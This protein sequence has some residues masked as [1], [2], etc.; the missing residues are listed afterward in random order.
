MNHYYLKSNVQIEPLFNQWHAHPYLIQP[1]TAAMYLVNAHLSTINSY[2]QMPMA[3]AAALKNPDLIGGPFIDFDGKRVDEVKALKA[4]SEQEFECHITLAN[5]IKKLYELLNEKAKGKPLTELYE[6]IPASIKKFVELVY[7]MEYQPSFRLI[8]NLLY[9]SEYYKKDA[10]TLS[11]TLINSDHRPFILST[12]RLDDEHMLQLPIDFSSELVDELMRLKTEPQTLE[13]IMERFDIKPEKEEVLKTLLTEEPHK[14][15]KRYDGEGVRARYFGHACVLLESKDAAVLT[16]PLISYKYDTDLPRYTY[17]DLPEVI[18]YV[19]ITHTHHDHIVIETLL[20]LREKIKNI[21]VPRAGIG[22]LE[23]PSM[24]LILQN[25]GFK[26]VFEIDEM[27][28]ISTEGLE[29]TGV[30]FFG[31]HCDLDIRSKSTYHLNFNGNTFLVAADSNS[32]NPEV[33]KQ[34]HEVLGDIDTFFVG[35]ECTGAPM[36]WAYGPLF[37]KEIDRDLDQIRRSNGSD[38]EAVMEMVDIFAFKQVYLYAMGAEPWLNYFMALQHK[39]EN[40]SEQASE[41]VIAACESRNIAS[42]RLYATKEMVFAS[43]EVVF[44]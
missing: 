23:D 7:D 13:Y 11:L 4:Y 19:V 42:E 18:D 16:D 1:A 15:T 33:Y 9:K 40:A 25:I 24:K 29:I 17:E 3:H 34:V 36:S 44:N 21:I 6:E 32:L 31:E 20:Q 2:V 10:Q 26:N 8:E 38:Y 28:T 27:E 5:D 39:H 14:I 22:S 37:P 12:P 41:Q 30:P 35:L 43:E